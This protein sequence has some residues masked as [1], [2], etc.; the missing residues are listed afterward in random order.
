MDTLAAVKTGTAPTLS[1][2]EN[3]A[4]HLEAPDA[5]SSVLLQ[6]S[7]ALTEL[8]PPTPT[9][10]ADSII[11]NVLLPYL[12]FHSHTILEYETRRQFLIGHYRS[13]LIAFIDGE[14]RL[15]PS[16]SYKNLDSIVSKCARLLE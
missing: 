14:M 2:S 4:V 1:C 9:E 5:P 8:T 10:L 15:A 6:L 3:S 12:H 7:A 13:Q 16:L 11:T